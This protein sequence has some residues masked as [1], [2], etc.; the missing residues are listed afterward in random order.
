MMALNEQ[1]VN[2]YGY[3]LNFSGCE[4]PLDERHMKIYSFAT[5]VLNRFN[6]GQTTV[7]VYKDPK[8]IFSPRSSVIIHNLTPRANTI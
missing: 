5:R 7:K 4:I 1:L 6:R 3:K 2:H 8:S